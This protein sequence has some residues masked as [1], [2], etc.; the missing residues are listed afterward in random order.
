MSEHPQPARAEQGDL[1]KM[2]AF[3][4]GDIVCWDEGD[5][6]EGDLYATVR[7]EELIKYYSKINPSPSGLC[8]R[9]S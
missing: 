9:Y 4:T 7:V 3:K 8:A 2:G 6:Y 5:L 1:H